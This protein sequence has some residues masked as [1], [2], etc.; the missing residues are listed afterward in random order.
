MVALVRHVSLPMMLVPL[1]GWLAGTEGAA[2]AF[3][4]GAAYSVIVWRSRKRVANSVLRVTGEGDVAKLTIEFVERRP[5]CEEHFPLGEVAD[6]VL[7]VKEIEPVIDGN[8]SLP[9]VRLVNTKLGPKVDIARI[10]IVD[11]TGRSVELTKEY[12]PYAHVIDSFGKIRVFL[13]KWGWVPEDER[14]ANVVDEPGGSVEGEAAAQD[15]H[16]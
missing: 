14:P 15:P 16:G 10:V 7:D 9:G 1:A 5:W 4:G 11:V 8:S 6:V 3:F 12:L 2:A 13:R